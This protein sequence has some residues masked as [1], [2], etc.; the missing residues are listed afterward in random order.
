VK[1]NVP[2]SVIARALGGQGGQSPP[3]VGYGLALLLRIDIESRELMTTN[4]GDDRDEIID[5]ERRTRFASVRS[6]LVDSWLLGYPLS[7]R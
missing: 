1:L 5:L 2:P 6:L 3:L 7:S 4:S